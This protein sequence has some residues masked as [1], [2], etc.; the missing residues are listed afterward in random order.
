MSNENIPAGYQLHLTTWENDGD[1]YN[2]EI[3]SGLTRED[4]RFFIQIASRFTSVNNRYGAIGGLGNDFVSGN[5]LIDVI[6]KAL[7]DNPNIS[8]K[9]REE[10]TLENLDDD[11][12]LGCQAYELLISVILGS[13]QEYD[14]CSGDSYFCRVFEDFKVFYYENIVKNCSNDFR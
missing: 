6:A 14:W 7:S 13:P 5:T 3:I 4:T 10:W 2:T 8:D 11:E 12:A 9:I 1:N